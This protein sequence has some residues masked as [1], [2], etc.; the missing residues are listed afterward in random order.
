MG[1]K[2]HIAKWGASLAVRIPKPIAE[3]WGVQDGSAIEIISRG[4]H[5]VLRKRPYDLTD[6]LAQIT[7]DNLHAEQNAGPA[8]GNE[9]SSWSLER[10]V[11]SQYIHIPGDDRR[12]WS[13]RL[14]PFPKDCH[15]RTR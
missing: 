8:Q 6:M 9:E 4:D 11:Q 12:V 10:R 5:V 14:A 2:S 13:E 1:A 7:D 15:P 3:Q